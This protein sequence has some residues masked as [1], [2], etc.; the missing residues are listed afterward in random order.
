MLTFLPLEE[1]Q[2]MEDWDDSR[3]NEK[4]DILAYEL[5]ALVHGNEEAD[6]ARETSR[7]LF[8]GGGDD[9]NMLR[10]GLHAFLATNA[11]GRLSVGLGEFLVFLL[12]R[13]I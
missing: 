2:A 6:K 8:A 7:S 11:R 10:A 4:K 1:I 9:A 5:T 3:I 12:Q 13:V